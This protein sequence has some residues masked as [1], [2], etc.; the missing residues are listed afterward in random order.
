MEHQV[1]AGPA[2][3]LDARNRAMHAAADG[4]DKLAEAV[5]APMLPHI[6]R[7]PGLDMLKA[8]LTNQD[9][10]LVST[11]GMV[12]VIRQWQLALELP[13]PDSVVLTSI[14][15]CSSCCT[16]GATPSPP[17]KCSRCPRLRGRTLS[18][19]LSRLAEMAPPPRSH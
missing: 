7:S 19:P 11:R 13:S 4:L 5:V 9:G 8:M 18:P 6:I 3:E 15:G 2:R 17:P 16:C 14:A 1:R 12:N 10:S